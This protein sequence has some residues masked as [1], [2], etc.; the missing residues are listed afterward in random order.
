M[1]EKLIEKIISSVLSLGPAAIFFVVAAHE[2]WLYVDPNKEGNLWR[3][4]WFALA[5]AGWT[6]LFKVLKELWDAIWESKRSTWANSLAVQLENIRLGIVWRLSKFEQQYLECQA[7]DCDDYE[8]EG[9]RDLGIR[10]PMLTEVFVPL[11]L[12]GG[13]MSESLARQMIPR[14]RKGKARPEQLD[15]ENNWKIWEFLAQTQHSPAYRRMAV[16]AAVG[17]GKTTLLKHITLSYARQLPVVREHNAPKLVPVL[18]YLRDLREVFAKDDLTPLTELIHEHHIPKLPYPKHGKLTPPSSWAAELLQTGRA[19]VMFDGF[20]EV[21]EAQRGKVSDWIS[22]EMRRYPRS[23]FILTSRPPGY[24]AHF[25]AEKPETTIS[26]RPFNA[27]QRR[28]FIKK[29]YLCQEVDTRK[30]RDTPKVRA[31]ADQQAESLL[32]QLERR[33]KLS[34]MANNPLLLNMIATFH[35]YHPGDDLPKH[36]A[37]LYEEICKLQLVNRPR[38]KGISMLLNFE[39]SSTLLRIIALQMMQHSEGRL[40]QAT[41]EQLQDWIRQRLLQIDHS[42]KPDAW[43][44][45][46]V[47]ISELLVEQDDDVYEFAHLSFQEF[48]AAAQ[49]K[50]LSLQNVV[51][52][53]FED[54]EWRET[55]LLYAAQTSPTP[56][57]QEACRRSTTDA[58]QLGYDCVRESPNRVDEA[59]FEELQE[60]RY[61]PL[62]TYLSQGDWK[63]ADEETLAVMLRTVGKTERGYLGPDDLQNFPCDDLRRIDKLWV[64]YSDG[65]FGFSIQKEIYISEQVGGVADGRYNSEAFDR[66]CDRIGWRVNGSYINYSQVT[67]DTSAQSGHLPRVGFLSLRIASGGLRASLSRIETCKL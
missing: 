66:F 35:R 23:V 16:L 46:V 17:Y 18:L 36:R 27:K 59:V 43:I 21:A 10:T 32:Q 50:A 65:R 4:F 58:L 29:W 63:A 56:L 51:L 3:A 20:D 57:A 1:S 41:K 28:E 26:V 47:E 25:T 49:L 44:R 31:A 52:E 6:F 2:C 42:T 61:Q 30:G 39:Q 5:G 11:E 13:H 53:R 60:R 40:T 33:E 38:A 37:K 55:I 19:L 24:E 14:R 48:F 64:S 45:Q 22:A 9:Y 54:S 67:F 8:V 62:S 34:A 15:Q 7:D 12:T